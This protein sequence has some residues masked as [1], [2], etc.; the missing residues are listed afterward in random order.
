MA[1]DQMAPD[2]MAPF[3][4]PPDKMAPTYKGAGH[5]GPSK[6]KKRYKKRVI[7]N[8]KSNV[9]DMFMCKNFNTHIV[10]V[11]HKEHMSMPLSAR[12]SPL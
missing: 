12:L 11:A 7:N 10:V 3:L 2:I 6:K 8:Y 4:Q 9:P 1:P 5:N